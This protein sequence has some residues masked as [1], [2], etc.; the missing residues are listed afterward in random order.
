MIL[1]NAHCGPGLV[2]KKIEL[3][4]ILWQATILELFG[5]AK[6]I[7]GRVPAVDFSK[8][9]GRPGLNARDGLI[10]RQI[11]RWMDGQGRTEANV[12]ESP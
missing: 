3:L 1:F 8:T 2:D 12:F 7:Q 5:N 11:D 6:R 10:D 4:R 9:S